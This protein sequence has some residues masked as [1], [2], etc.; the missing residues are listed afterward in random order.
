MTRALLP[1][2]RD[3][4]LPG[5]V[6]QLAPA[7]APRAALAAYVRLAGLAARDELPLAWPQV[8][9]FRLHMALLT[10]RAFPLP[11]WSA[12]QVRVRMRRLLELP[13]EASYALAVQASGMRRL[14][15][16]AE[17]DLWCTLR[18]ASGKLAWESTTT[19]YWRGRGRVPSDA[20]APEA[21]SPALDGAL[22]GE[23]ASPHGGGWRFGALTGDYNPLHWNDR[24]ARA[25]GFRR[26]FHHP[27][28]IAG[29]CL[30]R[31]AVDSAAQLELWIKGPVFYRSA[32]ALRAGAEGDARLFALHVDG[33]ERPALVG[34]WR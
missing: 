14:E 28:R 7:P 16:G 22:L 31:L 13:A 29:Q 9:G 26:A 18:D 6:L 15:K 8:W 33:E 17:V 12:L 5:L 27:A 10:D 20:P 34:R 19:F 24:Y 25:L 1:R 4:A 3:A 30:A 21:A 32:L 11:I 23:W 2:R